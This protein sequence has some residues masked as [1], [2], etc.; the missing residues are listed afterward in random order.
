[1]KPKLVKF[2]AIIGL[3]TMMFTACST[4]EGKTTKQPDVDDIVS[5]IEDVLTIPDQ[6]KMDEEVIFTFYDLTQDDIEQISSI[7]SGN[8]AN[9][10][11]VTVVKAAEGKID[12]VSKVLN[13][14]I[15]LI[16]SLFEEYNPEDKPKIDNAS[17][18]VNGNYALIAVCENTDDVEKIFEE[19]FK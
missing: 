3:I 9:A 19:S 16:A 7:K 10:D 15:G 12:K 14:R 1:M 2:I 17:V 13:D 5:S 18:V 6:V 11:E 4:H 8:G